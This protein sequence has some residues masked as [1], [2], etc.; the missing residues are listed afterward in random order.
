MDAG[1]I[2]EIQ[3]V[4]GTMRSVFEDARGQFVQDDEGEP[5]Y[6]V[7]FIPR[8]MSS[9]RMPTTQ[10]TCSA[11]AAACGSDGFATLLFSLFFAKKARQFSNIARPLKVG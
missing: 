7:W 2:A 5:I 3:F 11:M 8:D 1:A 6:G 10:G 4:D 9:A